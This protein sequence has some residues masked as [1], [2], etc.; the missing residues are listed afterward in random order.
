[1]GKEKKLSFTEKLKANL[2]KAGDEAAKVAKKGLDAAREGAEVVADQAT[3]AAKAG[4][5]AA[6]EGASLVA[7]KAGEAK[8]F[9]DE[10]TRS[11]LDH[12]YAA[13][14]KIAIENLARL[15]NANPT[16]SPSDILS[17][18]EADLVKAETKNGDDSEEF[19]S[20]TALYIFTAVEVYGS[21]VKD[22][23]SRQKLID[24]TVMIDSSAAKM[25]A[26]A[27]GIGI[28]ILLARF[29]A[30]DGVKKLVAGM[31]SAGVLVQILGI[32]NPGKKSATWIAVS[33]INKFLGEA[34]VTWGA[35]KDNA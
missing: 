20:A 19:A 18:L 12:A 25:A 9:L 13:K 26:K 6:K 32:K 29:G 4:A 10:K 34:P 2:T 28:G 21:Q 24:A 33:A 11:G 1:M 23:G 22:V 16:G 7:E 3:K 27:A 8:D 5:K 35:A 31:A 15:R 17:E 14:Q 30:K